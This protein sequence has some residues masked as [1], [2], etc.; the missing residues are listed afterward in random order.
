MFT[1]TIDDWISMLQRIVALIRD[2]ILGV[3][4]LLTIIIIYYGGDPTNL[5]ALDW[6][7]LVGAAFLIVLGPVV[8]FLIVRLFL[9][10][11]HRLMSTLSSVYLPDRPIPNGLPAWLA[12]RVYGL[13]QEQY[14]A[15]VNNIR[16]STTQ[17]SQNHR[18]LHWIFVGSLMLPERYFY[19][20]ARINPWLAG[21]LVLLFTSFAF[22]SIV[23]AYIP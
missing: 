5:N 17:L 2:L 4:A 12:I 14:E 7:K 18:R 15:A 9:R 3:V 22:R 10:L 13:S 16:E 21:I 1:E 6:G 8:S 20:Q 19:Y 11:V 23:G